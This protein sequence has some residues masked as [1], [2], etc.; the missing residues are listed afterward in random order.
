MSAFSP[1]DPGAPYPHA[2]AQAAPL[3]PEAFP[4]PHSNS[5]Q[6]H[7]PGSCP[8]LWLAHHQGPLIHHCWPQPHSRLGD[9]AFLRPAPKGEKVFGAGFSARSQPPAAPCKSL[10]QAL[11]CVWSPS[12][13]PQRVLSEASDVDLPDYPADLWSLITDFTPPY[14]SKFQGVPSR[15]SAPNTAIQFLE[16]LH[17]HL[18][19][20]LFGSRS[21]YWAP[22]TYQAYARPHMSPGETKKAQFFVPTSQKLTTTWER[23][24]NHMVYQVV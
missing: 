2:L 13:C 21:I 19:A 14:P 24:Y 8:C 5:T 6:Q 7:H 10:L 18:I 1:A 12:C 9:Q 3:T 15:K 22:T 20:I 4:N 23:I 11:L 16:L 17:T